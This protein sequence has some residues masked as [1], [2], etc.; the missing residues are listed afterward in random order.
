MEDRRAV[1][2]VG[3]AGP[4]GPRCPKGMTADA[5]R[6]VEWAK[7]AALECTC[8]GGFHIALPCPNDRHGDVDARP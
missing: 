7:D 2:P 1:G 3:S 6:L 4:I 8:E 5:A